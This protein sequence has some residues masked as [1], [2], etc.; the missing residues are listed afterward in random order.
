VQSFVES[1]YALYKEN[2]LCSL[3]SSGRERKGRKKIEKRKL[4]G[5]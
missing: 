4:E 1:F 3:R 2:I 5:K